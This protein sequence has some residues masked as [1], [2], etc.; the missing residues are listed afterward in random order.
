MNGNTTACI[1]FFGIFFLESFYKKGQRLVY[2]K[3][4]VVIQGEQLKNGSI[5]FIKNYINLFC[6]SGKG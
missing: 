3:L 4:F 2:I 6:F 1:C 5:P